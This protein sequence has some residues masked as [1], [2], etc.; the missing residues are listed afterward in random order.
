MGV[1]VIPMVFCDKVLYSLLAIPGH[2]SDR[3]EIEELPESG[4]L[5]VP[6]VLELGSHQ[7]LF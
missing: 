2:Q 1:I 7:H 4:L 6:P 3:L 5:P